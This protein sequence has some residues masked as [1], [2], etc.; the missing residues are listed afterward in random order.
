MSVVFLGLSMAFQADLPKLSVLR[1]LEPFYLS[2]PGVQPPKPLSRGFL[3]TRPPTW[4]FVHAF[5][6]LG[7][8]L[9]LW[10]LPNSLRTNIGHSLSN[11]WE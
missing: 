10:S 11:L 3:G 8:S 2:L 9:L 5:Y 7:P 6:G 1:Y 4:V